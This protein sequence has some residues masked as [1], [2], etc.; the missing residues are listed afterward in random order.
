MRTFVGQVIVA[1]LLLA[2]GEAF[3]RASHIEQRLAL[4]EENLATLSPDAADA[5]Y[6]RVEGE[7][8]VAG[9]LPFVGEPLLADVRQER[10]MVSY[11]RGDYTNVPSTEADLSAS[12]SHPDLIFLAANAVFRTVQGRRT[13]QAGAQDLD[14]VLRIY[15]LLLKKHPDYVDGS[16]NYEY[17]VRLRN[18]VARG[19]PNIGAA[20]GTQAPRDRPPSP[21]VH[22]EHGNPPVDTPPDQFNVI[23]PL[24]P[25]ERGDQMKA[26]AG[27][28]KTRKG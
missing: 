25:E 27:G 12:D 28:Q 22:G 20:P 23:V 18:I 4:A 7:M 6:A 5:E 13:G 11:W 1:A 24:R 15:S 8:A 2:G 9:R 14:G 21:S 3:R 17:V 19:K 16:Y 10:A 26:G